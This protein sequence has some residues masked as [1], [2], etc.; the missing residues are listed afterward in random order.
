MGSTTRRLASTRCHT[1]GVPLAPADP[2]AAV[3][4]WIE[5]ASAAGIVGHDTAVLATATPDG[6]PAARAVILRGLDDRGFVFFTDRRSRKGRELAANPRAALVMV[7]N[8]LERQVRAEGSVDEVEDEESDA[9]FPT[10][11]RGH[12]LAAWSSRQSEV[13]AD[14][15]ELERSFAEMQRR[16]DGQQ[17]VPR[18]PY[19]GG[20]RLVP[21]EIEL[22]Q[23]RPDRLH[24]R[25]RYRRSAGAWHAEQLWP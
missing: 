5:E 23:G 24:D 1:G 6:R 15:A 18:P 8:Q 9:Y 12:Q 20:Y 25:T 13:L 3:R 10:R 22:W 2:V 7:W 17:S 14:R 11:P 16:F 4:T 21:E 19:W